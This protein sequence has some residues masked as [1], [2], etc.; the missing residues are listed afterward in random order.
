MYL[1]LPE[2]LPE[3]P[4]CQQLV[5]PPQRPPPDPSGW[6]ERK[7]LVG[8]RVG[9]AIKISSQCTMNLQSEC[10]LPRVGG[11]FLRCLKVSHPRNLLSTPT[12]GFIFCVKSLAGPRTPLGLLGGA[13]PDDPAAGP[14]LSVSPW[15][16]RGDSW[17]YAPGELG[18]QTR[19]RVHFN[20]TTHIPY[21]NTTLTRSVADREILNTAK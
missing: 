20:Q 3:I 16:H 18:N 6:V 14:R 4:V 7:W 13:A 1:R 8:A 9:S 15:P 2:D 19:D 5:P 17:C 11:P 10:L 12:C 21:Q